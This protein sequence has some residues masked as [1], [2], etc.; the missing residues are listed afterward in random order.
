MLG[1]L[2]FRSVDYYKIEQGIL[3]EKF[4]EYYRFESADV[5]FGPK[6][7]NTLI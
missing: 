1:I 5:T 4:S 3:Q 7:N 2:D 6:G